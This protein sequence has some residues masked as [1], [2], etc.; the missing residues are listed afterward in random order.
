MKLPTWAWVLGSAAL[1][2]LIG[3]ALSRALARTPKRL[4]SNKRTGRQPTRRK[5]IEAIW[6]SDD[7]VRKNL[8]PDLVAVF[9]KVKQRIK[10]KRTMDRTEAF[11]QW[12]E[13]NPDAVVAV[14]AGAAEA[15]VERMVRE[16]EAHEA[17]RYAEHE[18]EVEAAERAAIEAS[19][20]EDAEL[21]DLAE[22]Y[23]AE[24]DPEEVREEE[25]LGAV[26]YGAW[27]A[28][29]PPAHADEDISDA[30]FFR[31][32]EVV[33]GTPAPAPRRSKPRGRAPGRPK[34]RSRRKAA[35][36]APS[37]PVRALLP[38]RSESQSA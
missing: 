33:E 7:A 2:L 1:G 35:S 26:E 19:A 14:Q 9:N 31:R 12:V 29:A 30:E 36:G 17:E 6:E 15:D 25:V 11:L 5:A 27:E 10:G 18:A 3:Y 28:V 20:A 8:P 38:A 24:P 16:H 23:A 37:G 4:T 34:G 21:A 32:L 22:R 13:E